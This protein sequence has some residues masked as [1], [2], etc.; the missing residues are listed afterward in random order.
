MG[1]KATIDVAPDGPL[2]IK[3]I[4][5]ITNSL[6]KVIESKETMAFC[7]CGASNNKPFCDGSHGKVNFSGKLEADR[8]KH[9]KIEYKG[10]DITIVDNEGVCSHAGF[11]DG[12]LPKVYW[13]MESG[14]RIPKPDSASKDENIKLIKRCPSGALSYKLNGKVF[15]ELKREPSVFVSRDGPLL[16]TGYPELQ[17]ESSS[18]PDSKEHYTLCRCGASKNKPFCD[19]Q[20]YYAQFKD[21]EN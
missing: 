7:R 21:G 17:D 1:E 6:G 15:D 11:C 12:T 20:H 2:I 14:K 5:K 16:I 18:K 10:K 8:S 19:G 4:K 9:K 3:N 13:D